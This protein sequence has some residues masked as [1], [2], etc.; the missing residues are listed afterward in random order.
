MTTSI[1]YSLADQAF[2]RTKS[3]GILNVSLSLF[4]RLADCEEVQAMTLL[5]NR[6]LN[7]EASSDVLS[8]VEIV[9]Y[10]SAVSSRINRI[11]WDQWGV[12]SAADRAGREW[13][14][15]P[16]GFAPF[17]RRPR[18][19]VA[20]YVHDTIHEHYRERRPSV[21]PTGELAYFRRCL[22]A[23]LQYARVIL[24]NSRFTRESLE[25]LARREGLTPPPIVV[26]GIGFEDPGV[27]PSA[28]GD[29]V[30]L[31]AGGFNKRTDLAVNHL[32]NWRRRSGYKG[33]IEVVG[34]APAGLERPESDAWVWLP[35][36]A[37]EAFDRKMREAQALLYTSEY[38]GFGMPPVEAILRGTSPVYSDLPS[39]R[40]VMNGAGRPFQNESFD[41]FA[42]ALDSA[43]VDD[44]GRIDGWKR[45]LL[46]Q[47]N[48]D[49]VVARVL[50]ALR[51]H[52]PRKA[53]ERHH[54]LERPLAHS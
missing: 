40:E 13:L 25:I 12:S 26:V 1:T 9:P 23:T 2:D 44:P 22:R 46:T 38:E 7:M 39:T 51:E 4:R 35:R 19:A 34:S 8:K 52:S 36:L 6:T 21:M 50:E 28:K 30:L 15:L 18:A 54:T 27:P 29:F 47:H 20:A 11:V 48:W 10:D 37:P 3:V 5:S 32:E 43:L 14:L 42:R 33:R 24:T 45:E 31:L 17:V 49:L 16:K 53:H 41:S